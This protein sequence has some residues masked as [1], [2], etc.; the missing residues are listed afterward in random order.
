MTNTTSAAPQAPVLAR[1]D[2]PFFIVKAAEHHT[3]GGLYRM[4]APH[5]LTTRPGQGDLIW[6]DGEARLALHE[7]GT[8]VVQAVATR[9][10]WAPYQDDPG[11]GHYERRAVR[12]T[13]HPGRS[14]MAGEDGLED[15]F[16]HP[17]LCTLLAEQVHLVRGRLRRNPNVWRYATVQGE[18]LG[19]ETYWGDVR[20]T[21]TLPA[22][23]LPSKE[24]TQPSFEIDR[25]LGDVFESEYEQ[26]ALRRHAVLTDLHVAGVSEALRGEVALGNYALGAASA[27]NLARYLAD[28]EAVKHRL[29]HALQEAEARAAAQAAQ[30]GAE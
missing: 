23:W 4:T 1:L 15:A 21:R 12:I 14:A 8:L 7:D 25:L 24:D 30:R 26:A 2:L 18:V 29:E 28:Q 6:A 13:S 19:G 3:R 27:E 20:E 11:H 10:E 16:G 5:V 17:V 9:E 22:P